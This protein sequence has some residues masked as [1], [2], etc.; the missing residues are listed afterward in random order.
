MASQGYAC[1]AECDQSCTS[2]LICSSRGSVCRAGPAQ[3]FQAATKQKPPDMSHSTS[4]TQKASLQY[5]N[6]RDATMLEGVNDMCT[7][8]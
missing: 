2:M 4:T 5:C 6:V 3:L 1:N 8:C 7:L